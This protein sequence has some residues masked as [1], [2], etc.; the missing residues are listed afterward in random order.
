MNC[1]PYTRRKQKKVEIDLA[2]YATKSDLKSATGDD[3]SKVARKADLKIR[4]WWLDIDKLKNVLID[5]HKLS[6]IAEKE[7][8][9][10][11]EYNEFVKKDLDC[12][13]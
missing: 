11:I 12:R 1:F 4:Y 9:K 3:T 7:I 6:N 5:L 2:N 10:N 13:N 8:V